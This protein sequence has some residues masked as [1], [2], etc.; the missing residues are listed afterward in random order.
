MNAEVEKIVLMKLKLKLKSVQ[1]SN[2][3]RALCLEKKTFPF[4]AG[5]TKISKTCSFLEDTVLIHP[6]T[7]NPRNHTSHLMKT[8]YLM[9]PKGKNHNHQIIASQVWNFPHSWLKGSAPNRRG[10]TFSI[11]YGQG[12]TILPWFHPTAVTGRQSSLQV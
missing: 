10:A 9:Y 8:F 6:N 4:S 11:H 5:K 2:M 1:H 3:Y 12:Y 7:T